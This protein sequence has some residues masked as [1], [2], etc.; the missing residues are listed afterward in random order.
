LAVESNHIK[1]RNANGVKDS[2]GKFLN[3]PGNSKEARL[4]SVERLKDNY[5]NRAEIWS[6]AHATKASAA[7]KKVYVTI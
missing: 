3:M 7:S 5:L 2:H 4:I 1:W 6:P